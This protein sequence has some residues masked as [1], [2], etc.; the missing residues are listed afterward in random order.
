VGGGDCVPPMAVLGAVR[1]LLPIRRALLGPSGRRRRGPRLPRCACR[2]L[3][4]RSAGDRRAAGGRRTWAC[5][6]WAPEWSG[7]V[8]IVASSIPCDARRARRR[9]AHARPS[10]RREPS[11]RATL[12][13][14][15]R[16]GW[17]PSAIGRPRGRPPEGLPAPARTPLRRGRGRRASRWRRPAPN[18]EVPRVAVP[19]SSEGMAMQLSMTYLPNLRPR[20]GDHR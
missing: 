19:R 20:G 17:T 11:G 6:A 15:L 7:R 14:W 3:G 9:R 2:C 12:A 13:T 8:R 10:S 4:T 16:G 5:A 1:L 18:A